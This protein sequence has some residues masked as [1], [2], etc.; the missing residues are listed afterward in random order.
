MTHVDV[1]GGMNPDNF[2]G[3]F[4]VLEH[5]QEDELVLRNIHGALAAGG[6]LMITVPQH[7]RLWSHV[8]EISHHVRRY[9]ADE[10]RSK[11]ESA[12]FRVVFSGSYTFSL[13]PFMFASR[14]GN[15]RMFPRPSSHFRRLS[16]LHFV[17][18]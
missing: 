17:R 16:T 9:T 4:D 2:I 12:G 18:Y 3:A 6:G 14:S 13:L 1:R 7:R 10:L 15:I 11:V 5:I 8:D